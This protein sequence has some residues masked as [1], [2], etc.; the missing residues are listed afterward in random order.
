[1]VR[2][3]L[4][5]T[6]GRDLGRRARWRRRS[7]SRFSDQGTERRAAQGLIAIAG[8]PVAQEI[9]VDAAAARARGRSPREDRRGSRGHRSSSTTGARNTDTV[10]PYHDRVTRPCCAGPACLARGAS[11]RAGPGAWSGRATSDPEQLAVHWLGAR[12]TVASGALHTDRRGDRAMEA[13]AFDR[14]A[15]LYGGG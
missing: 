2:H 14:A 15:H 1:M 8:G 13:L 10:E 12:D 9:L 3:R 7:A 4:T 6:A 5:S 11:P